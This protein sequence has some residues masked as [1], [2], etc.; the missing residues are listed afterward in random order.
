M[1]LSGIETHPVADYPLISSIYHST[2][3]ISDAAFAVDGNLDT[4]AFTKESELDDNR[5]WE[6]ELS[7]LLTVTNVT[8]T[9]ND[10]VDQHQQYKIST[11]S[12]SGFLHT[13]KC[14]ISI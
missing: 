5:W 1:Y 13:L 7:N 8:V 6:V 4:C 11:I 10:V 9:I 2:T 14:L 3:N 12:K